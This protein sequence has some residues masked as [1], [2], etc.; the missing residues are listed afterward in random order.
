[1]SDNI[2]YLAFSLGF[3]VSRIECEKG[4]MYKGEMR[5]GMYQRMNIFGEGIEEIPVILERKKSLPREIKKRAACQ[6]FKVIPLD[7]GEYC[8]ILV[9]GDGRF[10]SGDFLIT[11]S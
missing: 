11:H 3:M 10:L 6:G 5:N 9:S 4:C 7:M 1:M 8:N 2:E